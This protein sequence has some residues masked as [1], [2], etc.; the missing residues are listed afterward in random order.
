MII[1]LEVFVPSKAKPH[2]WFSVENHL[3]F[4]AFYS[5]GTR[6]ISPLRTSRAPSA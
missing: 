5:P 1:L 4:K 3:V 6:A 2:R